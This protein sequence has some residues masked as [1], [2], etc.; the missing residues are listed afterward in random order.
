MTKL[1]LDYIVNQVDDIKT[2]PSIMMEVTRLAEDP[3]STVKDMEYEILKDHVLTAK[4]LRLANS[5]YYGYARSISTVSQATVLLGFQTVKSI[6]LASTVN[7]FLSTEL[8]GYQLV[9]NEL[10]EQSQTC[11]LISR[12]IAQ[13]VKYKQPEEA[14]IA[15]LLRDIGKTVLNQHM[16]KQYGEVLDLVMDGKMSFIEAEKEIFGFDHAEIGGKIAKKWNMPEQL[17]ETISFHHSPEKSTLAPNL[18]A[19]VHLAD[20]ITMMMG[21]GIG[22]DGLA[23]NLSEDALN[24]LNLTIEDFE[25]IVADSMDLVS[26][27]DSF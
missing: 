21:I 20:A 19:I 13:V 5:A 6:A 7:E 1:T 2:L 18:V 9:E 25:N 26:D 8:K 4:V 11:G 3:D 12:Y 15:G 17:V 22:L 23:Y 16:E 27:I 10:W 14:Y 24:T